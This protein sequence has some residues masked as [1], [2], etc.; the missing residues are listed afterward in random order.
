M[1]A[2]V[3]VGAG[4]ARGFSLVELMVAM[5]LGLL[6]LGGILAAYLRA[7]DAHAAGES[8]AR[9]QENA[10]LALA[11]LAQDLR[12]AGYWGLTHRADLVAINA[13]S[14]FP[15]ACGAT[16]VTDLGHPV[17]G[18]DDAYGAPCAASGG[19]ALAGTDTLVVR[20][21]SADRLTPQS[22]TIAAA[23]RTRVLIVTSRTGGEL[24]VPAN[25]GGS[26][27][28]GFATADVPGQPPLADTRPLRVHAYYVSRN[29]SLAS[30]YPALRRKTLVAGP[31][32]GEEELLPGVEDLQV[33][34]GIDSDGD[35]E[36]DAYANP[37]A[38]PPGA[39]VVTA[40]LW[41]RLRALEFD[42]ADVPP[43]TFD[44]AG[45]QVT[46]PDDHHRRLLVATTV[47]LRNAGP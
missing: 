40:R 12:M 19:G 34:F 6:V 20:H 14:A 9:L 13:A 5:L 36:A 22:A 17:D 23:D 18:Y 46:A 2:D 32:I 7:R 42:A 41:L 33:R 21:A 25:T 29:S 37:G 39:T 4:K 15:G 27:P 31:A 30:G 45:R 35:G 1:T 16:W 11:I 44:Y 3:A 24:F 26:L 28:A 47:R 43:A 8:S 10:R 38:V